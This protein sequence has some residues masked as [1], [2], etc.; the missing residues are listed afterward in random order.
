MDKWEYKAITVN[1]D[2]FSDDNVMKI[3]QKLNDLGRSGWELVAAAP[4]HPDILNNVLYFKRKI[5]S[6]T[7]NNERAATPNKKLV[8]ATP[9]NYV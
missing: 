7:P 5:E 9:S 3:E 8:L 4:R 1:I 2:S 6:A